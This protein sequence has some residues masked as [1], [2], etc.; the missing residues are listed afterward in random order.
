[1]PAPTFD[2]VND[3]ATKRS[4]TVAHYVRA[5]ELLVKHTIID[6]VNGAKTAAK[7]AK[8]SVATLIDYAIKGVD[9]YAKAFKSSMNVG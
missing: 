9:L 2:S 7:I 4:P 8:V 5:H 1:M 6:P 3:A